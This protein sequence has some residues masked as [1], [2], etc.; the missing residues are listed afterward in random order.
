MTNKVLAKN[1]LFTLILYIQRLNYIFFSLVFLS[2]FFH[3]CIR[4]TLVKKFMLYY[5]NYYYNMSFHRTYV[6]D[7]LKQ[8]LCP[9]LVLSS[10]TP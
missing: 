10:S 1:L 7:Q 8:A 4:G 3:I 9:V 2:S 6:I 5:A